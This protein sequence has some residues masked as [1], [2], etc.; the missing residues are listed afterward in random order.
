MLQYFGVASSPPSG[1]Q[2]TGPGLAP[3]EQLVGVCTE[4]VE[5]RLK[6]LNCLSQRE[7]TLA[8]VV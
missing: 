5:Q 6:A 7:I 8:V 3:A 1:R 2:L 4:V